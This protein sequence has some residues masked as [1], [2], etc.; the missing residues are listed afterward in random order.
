[1]T[2]WVDAVALTV[3]GIGT[4]NP[5]DPFIIRKAE[6]SI[7]G[8]RPNHKETPEGRATVSATQL[9]ALT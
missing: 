2:S 5:I 3:N 7:S 9:E 4:E 6:H 1:M 8:G